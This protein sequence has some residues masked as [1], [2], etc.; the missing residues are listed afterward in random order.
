MP[1]DAARLDQTLLELR[2]QGQIELMLATP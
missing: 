2:E 1:V